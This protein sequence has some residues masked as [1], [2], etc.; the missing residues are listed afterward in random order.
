MCFHHFGTYYSNFF[1]IKK[2]KIHKDRYKQGQKFSGLRYTFAIYW[3]LSALYKTQRIICYSPN[4][5]N[6]KY[7][8]F[9]HNF[10]HCLVDTKQCEPEVHS[11]CVA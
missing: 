5:V 8:A 10:V 7:L 6:A 9:V 11:H 1:I 3:A 4:D 2:T